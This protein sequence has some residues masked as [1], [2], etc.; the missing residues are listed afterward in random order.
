ML[1]SKYL[2]CFL[3]LSGVVCQS[4]FSESL[5]KTVTQTLKNSPEM[6]IAIQ[7]YY[8]SQEGLNIARGN[9]LPNLDLIADTG[10][11]EI[12]RNGSSKTDLDRHNTKIRF[13]L[14]LFRGFSNTKEHDRASFEMQATY[15]QSLAE[16]ERISL[17]ITK[18]Y[19][20]VLRAEEIVVLSIEDLK[21]HKKI[22]DLIQSREKQGVADKADL[23]QISSR[24]ARSRAN[25]T[26]AK[27]NLRDAK[28]TFHR[29]S[30]Y[31]AENLNRPQV[32]HAYLPGTKE[33]SLELALANNQS[34]QASQFFVQS[35]SAA[36]S[37]RK[38]HYYPNFDLVADRTWKEDVAGFS[39]KEDEWR[40]L[41]EM[42]WNFYA[43]GRK[44]AEY[45]KALY[46][47]ESAKMRVNKVFRDVQANVNSSWD[48]YQ[49]LEEEISYLQDYVEQTK[50]TERLYAQQFNVGRRTLLD[51]LDSQNELF[52]ARKAYVGSDYD[53]LYSQYRVVSSM[54]YIL[55]ALRVNVMEGLKK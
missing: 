39:G 1:K 6:S 18:A 12:E 51:L 23:S 48:A 52:Q 46:Q 20:D 33:R 34:L 17:E 26:S 38:S 8:S 25:L 31:Q 4:V 42:N 29:I 14:P 49:S 40:V 37:S 36:S 16:A 27:N 5:E 55:D 10:K 2:R 47:E 28:T 53:Y 22:H 21:A 44:N 30:G 54:S 41:V 24:L 32:D 45:K 9:F 13:S 7:K 19:I 15:Y 50:N 11:E 43:G 35:A 3:L